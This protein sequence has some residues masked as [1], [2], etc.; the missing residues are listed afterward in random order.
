[1]K[2]DQIKD[3]LD[4]YQDG[5][6]SE[7]ERD[8]VDGWYNQLTSSLPHI[9]AGIELLDAKD[10]VWKRLSEDVVVKKRSTAL[11]SRYRVAAAIL[12]LT[13]ATGIAFF[14]A[15]RDF[16]SSTNVTVGNEILP[17]RVKATL[18][19]SNGEKL[20]LD[21][22]QDGNLREL[23]GMSIVT[24]S[25]GSLIYRVNQDAEIAGEHQTFSTAN[26][27]TFGLMLPDGTEVWLN[28][29]STLT[30]SS[31]I[32]HEQVRKVTLHGEAYFQVAKSMD[33]GFW[34]E[35]AGQVVQVLGTHFNVNAYDNGEVVTTLL[36]GSVK[37]NGQQ[38][39]VVLKPNQ[40][41]TLK[42]GKLHIQNA[43][44][45]FIIAWKNGFFLFNHE[46]LGNIMEKVARW[47][48]VEID[49]AD[50]ELKNKTF[51]GTISRFEKISELFHM[52]EATNAIKFE[53]KGKKFLVT[54]YK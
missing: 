38:E 52:L 44:A 34:V 49:Y 24:S 23:P 5:R 28:A 50:P 16:S 13:I 53:M 14:K 41:S 25:D 43:E 42:R 32:K 35:S 39:S 40:Q 26:G 18:T 15:K 11:L 47:Y 8:L 1:M 4:K 2:E 37:V 46:S 54:K 27:E 29:A 48:N 21:R 3:L 19:L 17:G 22:G 33:K 30:Y 10:L 6:V 12:L 45:D 20:S 9:P 31:N 7:T 36:E 51:T